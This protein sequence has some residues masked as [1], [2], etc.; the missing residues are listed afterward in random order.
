MMPPT[1][2]KA[3]LADESTVVLTWANSDDEV[4]KTIVE[5]SEDGNNYTQ[6]ASLENG[7]TS[8]TVSQL[9]PKQVYFFRLKS[10]KGDKESSY[11]S[12][13]IGRASCRERV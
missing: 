12:V 3:K 8:Y 7:E 10:I 5:Q 9:T 1:N 13:K 2:V 4:E 11:S 6:I